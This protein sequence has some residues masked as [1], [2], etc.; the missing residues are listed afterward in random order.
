MV[1]G[2]R[3]LV[4]ARARLARTTM[5]A[6]LVFA[7]AIATDAAA[8]AGRT[9]GRALEGRWNIVLQLDSASARYEPSQWEAKGE[10][11]FSAIPWLGSSDRFGRHSVDLRP[12]FGRS[13]TSPMTASSFTPAD[14]SFLTEISGG[15]ARDSVAIDFIPRLNHYGLS[16]RGRYFGDS[17]RGKWYRRGSDGS[18][19]FTIR[20][21]SR[22][23][24][25]LAGIPDPTRATTTVVTM[26]DAAPAKAPPKAAA[27]KAAAPKATSKSARVA[28][29]GTPKSPP[30]KAATTV[31]VAT[32]PAGAATTPTTVLA[33]TA[34]TTSGTT[35]SATPA[36]TPATTPSTGG[37]ASAATTATAPPPPAG[38]V[39][40]TI[41]R[42]DPDPKAMGGV[43]VR[44]FDKAS[45]RWFITTYQLKLPNGKL[46]WGNMRSGPAPEGFG[47]VV[48]QPEGRYDVMVEN[49]LC[50]D[51]FWFFAKNVLRPVV[52]REGEIVDVTIVVDLSAEP[53]RKTIDNPT[54]ARC[55]AGPGT[56][57]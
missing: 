50:G 8:Q 23:A 21:S 13:F 22:E 34:A 35:S 55:T 25:N 31:A 5:R 45:Q 37:V 44:M 30:A 32:R 7:L 53:A 3:T 29:K 1:I 38:P 2:H 51:K 15:V 42:P 52:V 10:L 56:P 4:S 16:L 20:R 33:T 6:F 9:D 46:R 28:A 26:A 11:A 27:P 19:R 49:F 18:G 57:R 36:A 54:G 47:A 41:R 43:R 40:D 24:V 39:N 14:T 48:R 17:A 12:F